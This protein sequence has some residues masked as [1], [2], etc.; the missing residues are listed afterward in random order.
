ML[1]SMTGFGKIT[2]ELNDEQITVEIKTLNSKQIDIS[3]RMPSQYREY[4]LELRK[5]LTNALVRGKVEMTISVTSSNGKV[6]QKINAQIFKN[7]YDQLSQL[8]EQYQLQKPSNWFELILSMPQ[9]FE[10]EEK[11]FDET[12]WQI[13][14]TTVQ[15]ALS[16]VADFRRQEGKM[17][18]NIFLDKLKRI[19]SLL[20]AV[21]PFEEDRIVRIKSR[22]KEGLQQVD[23][24]L[25][26]DRLEQEMIY[27]IEK[28]DINEEKTRLQNHLHYF[29]ETMTK[30][31]NAGKKLGFIAQEM[32]REINTLGSKANHSE[33][34]KMVVL[35]KDELEQMKEQLFNVL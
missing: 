14:L 6:P 11:P 17:L 18:E 10:N 26:Q 34:Q 7:Y 28:L 24:A 19:Q 33:I 20:D 8:A 22:L 16:A 35:M 25:N 13:I 5:Q 4:E 2:R 12:E 9:L 32:G 1:Q 15:D 21:T 23:A 31:E 29:Q 27:Y 30:E 3:L